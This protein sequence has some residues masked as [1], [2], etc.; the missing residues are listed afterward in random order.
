[1]WSVLF[2]FLVF[3]FCPIIYLFTFRV[4]CCDVCYDFRI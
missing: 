3:V 2:I 1:V 4:P